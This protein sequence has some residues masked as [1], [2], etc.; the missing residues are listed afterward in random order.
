MDNFNKLQADILNQGLKDNP[1]LRPHVVPIINNQ[2]NTIQKESVIK[3]VN[4]V[5]SRVI[6]MDRS[7]T[8]FMDELLEIIGNWKNNP[9]FKDGLDLMAGSLI[10]SLIYLNNVVGVDGLKRTVVFYMKSIIQENQCVSLYIPF[11]GNLKT[12]YFSSPTPPEEDVIGELKV[13]DRVFEIILPTN[14]NLVVKD[15]EGTLDNELCE[16]TIKSG[17]E[18]LK[19]VNASLDF[20][21]INS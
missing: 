4:E 19:N 20:I 1:H 2:L 7:L 5:Y 3:A 17:G 13:G 15:I 16:F 9:E 10:E 11:K 12:I 8:T 6:I 18:G 21:Q 14:E